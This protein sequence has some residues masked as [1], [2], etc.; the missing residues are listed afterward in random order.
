MKFHLYRK[1]SK[2]WN[3]K[4]TKKEKLETFPK[5]DYE[6]KSGMLAN[7]IAE[8]LSFRLMQEILQGEKDEGNL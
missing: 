7:L 2:W 3:K 8:K 5:E 1:K 4:K 6:G